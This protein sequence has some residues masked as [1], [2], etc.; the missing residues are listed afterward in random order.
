MGPVLLT[1]SLLHLQMFA[2]ELCTRVCKTPAGLKMHMKKHNVVPYA[3]TCDC[4]RVLRSLGAKI[5]HERLC[6][7]ASP[8]DSTESSQV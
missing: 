5:E 4:G 7:G 1:T 6:K 8:V 3:H 2:C